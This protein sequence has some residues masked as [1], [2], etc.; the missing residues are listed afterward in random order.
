ME[1]IDKLLLQ[2]KILLLELDLVKAKIS[3]ARATGSMPKGESSLRRETPAKEAVY[4]ALV[5]S[6]TSKVES[7]PEQTATGKESANPLTAIILPK[8][9]QLVQTNTAN[10]DAK[11]LPKL[12]VP[13][14]FLRP[15][16]GIP[17]PQKSEPN[18]SVVLHRTESGIK[19]P[20]T[21]YYVVFN[22]PY[23][24][25]YDNWATTKEAI[26]GVSG[27]AHKKFT[28]ITKAR[29]AADEYTNT[30]S[31]ERL[32]FIPK[33]DLLKPKTFAKA[34]TSL[35]KEKEQWL[36]LGKPKPKKDPE[37]KETSFQPEL[38]R[39]S[40]LYL[41]DLGRKFNGDGDD[42]VFTTDKKNISMFNFLK[43]ADPQMVY[44]CFQAGLIKTI[45]PSQNL[46]EIKY[47]PKKIKDAVKR[48]RTNCIKNT[49]KDIF[50]KIK[51][52]IP[53]WS[54]E[55]LLH[56]PKY[57]IEIGISRKVQPEQSK[58]MENTIGE[59]ELVDLAVVTA[60]QF[61]ESLMKISEKDKIFV[62]MVDYETMVYS[63]NL[64]KTTIEDEKAIEVFQTKLINGNL[65]GFHC[66]AICHSINVTTKKSG[67]TYSCHLCKGKALVEDAKG[68][69]QNENASTDSGP[70]DNPGTTITSLH[71]E[72]EDAVSTTTS[73]SK[74]S[75]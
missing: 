24:G 10:H 59:D 64:K 42:T 70:A 12:V 6:T 4:S 35:T 3:L 58:T 50:L 14:D 48:F 7:T 74:A 38:S 22:G 11:A 51:S 62:N 45:Y 63:K 65:L 73:S 17:I 54:S 71:V 37:P 69:A 26:N 67:G 40:F 30:R 75:G 29:T 28:S 52:T 1:E 27:V 41:H 32:A 16:Q 21:S 53:V 8:D 25:I 15:H 31:V 34:L 61:I 13:T 43:K 9:K 39:D 44:E 56:K 49:E 47:L 33:G 23:A 46:Q 18:S 5:H 57:L 60:Q 68:K 2:E 36:V 72:K 20:Q 66:P 55:G 19:I